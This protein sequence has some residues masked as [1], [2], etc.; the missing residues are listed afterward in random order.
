MSAHLRHYL[1]PSVT[2]ILNPGIDVDH[3]GSYNRKVCLDSM[4]VVRA[5]KGVRINYSYRYAYAVHQDI[6][7]LIAIIRNDGKGFVLPLN[8]NNFS[9]RIN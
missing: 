1:S 9:S 7:Y 2:I 5:G 3:P 6:G 4:K 8:D